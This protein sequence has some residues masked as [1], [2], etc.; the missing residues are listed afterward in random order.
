MVTQ[1]PLPP[2]PPPPPPPPPAALPPPP[3]EQLGGLFSGVIRMT[4][5]AEPPPGITE[6]QPATHW[7]LSFIAFGVS[8]VPGLV[9][10]F[11]S[12]RVPVAYEAGDLEESRR[13][14]ALAK[15]WGI[16]GCIVGFFLIL[17]IASGGSSS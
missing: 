15:K 17:A 5:T 13:V 11:Y 4:K 10:L 1:A 9:A 2:A 3:P 14:S 16:G 6:P 8:L 7:L 12:Y